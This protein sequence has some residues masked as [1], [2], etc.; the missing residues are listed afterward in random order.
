MKRIIVL[1][2]NPMLLR[3]YNKILST[4]GYNVKLAP[5]S[6]IFFPLYR[7][8]IPDLII[9]DICLNNSEMNG[10]EV[11]RKLLDQYALQAKVIVLSGE[12]SRTEIAES[13][14]LGA[15]TFIEKNSTFNV[16]KFL[17]DVRQALALK[18]QEEAYADLK[19]MNMKLK[20]TYLAM[21]PFIGES[22][23]I[24]N[25][26]ERICKYAA[27]DTD[28]MF[29]GETGTGKEVAAHYYY[30]KSQRSGHQFITINAGGLTESII[31]SELFG[32]RRGSFTGAVE[33]KRGIFE[34]AS[35]GTLFLDEISNLSLS[36][37]AKILRAI[38]NKE[39]KVIGGSTIEVD[40]RLIMASNEDLMQAVQDGKFRKDLYFRLEGNIIN[41]PPLRSRG[42]DILLLT[43]HFL[44]HFAYKH[45][46]T[47]DVSLPLLKDDLMSYSWMGNVRELRKFCEYLSI[48]NDVITND[49]IRNELRRKKAG[50]TL[51]DNSMESFFQMKDFTEGIENFEKHY[52]QYHLNKHN[53][54]VSE[55]A[56]DLNLDRSTLYK[57]IKR[58]GLII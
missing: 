16:D 53:G 54:K 58:F 26:K 40:V 55:T 37:Q 22:P 5:S 21:N 35:Q 50:N 56:H 32:H 1:E 52:L 33:T 19:Q 23:E 2:D 9:L 4:A 41:I 30:W 44:N 10:L 15:Y 11:F 20:S 48:L 49:T 34:E 43:E 42:N 45:K 29:V 47:L 25:V 6:D 38:E 17:I 51:A 8:F 3:T 36:T 7:S 12:A 13:M 31:D 14:K 18:E 28:V 24:M 57:K 39:V 46:R 27:A